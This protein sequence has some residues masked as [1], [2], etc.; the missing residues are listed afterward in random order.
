ATLQMWTHGLGASLVGVGHTVGRGIGAG[1]RGVASAGVTLWVWTRGLGAS[2]VG[3]GHTVG[4]GIGAGARGVASARVTLRVW[5]HGLGA[6][7]MGGRAVGRRIRTRMRGIATAAAGRSAWRSEAGVWP[8]IV[9][10]TVGRA[11]ARSAHEVL[12]AGARLW[13]WGAC[14]S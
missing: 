10:R 2:L 11:I 14:A 3:V 12:A 4:R 1:A 5:T 7:L 8:F 9:T 13:A 6:S